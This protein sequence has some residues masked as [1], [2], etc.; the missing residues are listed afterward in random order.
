MLEIGTGSDY[1]TAVMV[2]DATARDFI[3]RERRARAHLGAL[4][5]SAAAAPSVRLRLSPRA[6]TVLDRDGRRLAT[7]ILVKHPIQDGGDEGIDGAC[8]VG[9]YPS[10]DGARALIVLQWRLVFNCYGGPVFATVLAS[11]T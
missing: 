11:L 5:V 9:V 8:I 3:R 10:P 1:R 2:I 4:H 6:A 7:T